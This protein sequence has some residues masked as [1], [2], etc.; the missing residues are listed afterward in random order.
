MT[1][2][3]RRSRAMGAIIFD[4]DGLILDTEGP[5]FQ[6]WSEIYA[7]HGARLDL[8]TWAVCIGTANAF[9]PYADLEARIGHP[10]RHDEVRAERR[11][12]NNELL[13]LQ[14]VQPGVVDYIERA[15]ELG[16]GLGVA[17][18]SHR[19]W[20]AGHLERL[21]LLESF[22]FLSCADDVARVKPDP[23]LYL[24]AL[25][26][27]GVAADQAIALEDSPNGILAAKRAGIFCV[28]VPN[29]L[30]SQLPLDH[31]DLRLGSLADVRLDDLLA[32]AA[33]V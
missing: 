11:Q 26:A 17:S 23:E 1:A 29:P 21:G 19:S 6:T 3:N 22:D 30:T 10:I 4:F 28:A 33:R 16:L 31:A 12:R 15:K 14:G 24:R 5:E 2:V 25:T 7:A 32:R 8:A 13:A 18:S 20:V 9:D 27:L